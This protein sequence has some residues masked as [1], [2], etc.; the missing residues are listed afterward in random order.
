MIPADAA[1]HAQDI[2][3]PIATSG[4]APRAAAAAIARYRAAP[5]LVHLLNVQPPLPRH[6]ARFFAQ[7]DLDAFHLEAGMHVLAQAIAALDAAGVA[8]RDHVVVGHA[9]QA[10]AQFAEHHDCRDILLEPESG[11]RAW[12]HLG[13]LHHQVQHLMRAASDA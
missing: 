7:R 10:I 9:A 8:H 2:L 5:A 3:V 13:S 11:L 12:L 6:V 4:D 1:A